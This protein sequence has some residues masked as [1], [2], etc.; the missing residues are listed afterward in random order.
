MEDLEQHKN[1]TQMYSE[2]NK[3]YELLHLVYYSSKKEEVIKNKPGIGG[4]NNII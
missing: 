1:C 2:L 4:D 3:C